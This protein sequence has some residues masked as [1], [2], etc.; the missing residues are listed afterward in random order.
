MAGSEA[1]EEPARYA[2]QERARLREQIAD[3]HQTVGE[4]QHATEEVM[5]RV[6]NKLPDPARVHER[7]SKL[8]EQADGHLQR[9][10]QERAETDA[11]EGD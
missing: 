10:E 11:A 4:R 5:H 6:A 3:A 7:A 1:S 2:Q 9:A 8:S